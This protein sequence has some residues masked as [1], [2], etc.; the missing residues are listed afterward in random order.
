M[1]NF[2]DYLL[3][4]II[5]AIFS[6]GSLFSDIYII[7]N[8]VFICFF[9]LLVLINKI[10]YKCEIKRK[11]FDSNGFL[12]IVLVIL[13]NMIKSFSVVNICFGY[14][15][16]AYILFESIR[17]LIAKDYSFNEMKINTNRL[18]DVFSL[19]YLTGILVMILNYQI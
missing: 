7:S 12:L 19:V 4:F 9:G 5:I 8:I 11:A 16:L 10:K 6:D 1:S 15:Y 2:I 17:C 3:V 18:F 14:L 13:S